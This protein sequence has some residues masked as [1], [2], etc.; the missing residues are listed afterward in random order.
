MERGAWGKR[1]SEAE[2]AE[3]KFKKEHLLRRLIC[4][5]GCCQ[6]DHSGADSKS[7]C[8]TCSKC[9]EFTYGWTAKDDMPQMIGIK[10]LLDR[11][12]REGAIPPPPPLRDGLTCDCDLTS[13]RLHAI[14]QNCPGV[15]IYTSLQAVAK[16]YPRGTREYDTA[17]I[18]LGHYHMTD[19]TLRDPK[20]VK[21]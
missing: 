6:L 16:D 21:P 11:A 7:R 1:Q 4:T 2:R 9:E 13:P 14:T 19:I 12:E 15:K 18:A 5:C 17:E 8:M 3:A 10:A 20:W